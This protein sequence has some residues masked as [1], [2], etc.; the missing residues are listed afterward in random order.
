MT[1]HYPGYSSLGNLVRGR[2]PGKGARDDASPG[3]VGAK[4]AKVKHSEPEEV[5]RLVPRIE[6]GHYADGTPFDPIRYIQCKVSL[7]ADRLTS[8]SA[9]FEVGELVKGPAKRNGIAFREGPYR[10][11]PYGIREVQFLDTADFRLYNNAFILRK[12]VRYH[13]GFPEGDPE[14]VFKFRHPDAQ[15]AAAMDVRPNISGDY[16]IKFKAQALPT[17]VSGGGIRMLYSH[18]VQFTRAGYV[19]EDRDPSAFDSL[20]EALPLLHSIKTSPDERVELVNG[21]IVEEVDQDVGE[22]TFPAGHRGVVNLALWR[23]RGEHDPLIGELSFQIRLKG[24]ER[25]T[26]LPLERPYAF[27]MQLQEEAKDWMRVGVT[28]TGIV[29]HL[30]GNPP[31]AHE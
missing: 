17:G 4:M 24:S 8:R 23:T 25:I 14:I 9:L 11:R 12:R 18:N 27:F 7:K 13:E 15:T 19:V 26:D 5:S 31:N 10:R 22:L 2:E 28:K 30:K 6:P 21:T 20:T 16:Q 1:A 3:T 29:Y